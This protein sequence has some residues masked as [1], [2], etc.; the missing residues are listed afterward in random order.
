MGFVFGLTWGR[1]E[2]LPLL[3]A[4]LFQL[5]MAALCRAVHVEIG[6]SCLNL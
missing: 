2:A 6:G 1:L 4:Q 3:L 5:N